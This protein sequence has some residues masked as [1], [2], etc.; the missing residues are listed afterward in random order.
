MKY[1]AI[2]KANC[3]EV[4]GT[5]IGEQRDVKFLGPRNNRLRECD[6]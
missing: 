6:L 3:L 2:G 4:G 5:Q 1:F